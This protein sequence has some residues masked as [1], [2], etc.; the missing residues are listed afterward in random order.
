MSFADYT[1]S[2]H[3]VRSDGV[4]VCGH[5][6]PIGPGACPE[7][8]ALTDEHWEARCTCVADAEAAAGEG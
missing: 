7:C 4:Q 5:K 3:Y 8:H 1:Q 6:I 2:G